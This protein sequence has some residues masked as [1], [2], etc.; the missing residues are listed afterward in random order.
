MG[1][2]A[3]HDKQQGFAAPAQRGNNMKNNYRVQ[4][5]LL[6]LTLAIF[7]A[8]C[9][10]SSSD[11]PPDGGNGNGNG[12]GNGDGETPELVADAGSD[13]TVGVGETV[14][15]DGSDSE[16]DIASYAWE[17]SDSSGVDIEIDD[18]DQETASFEATEAGDFRFL[19]RVTDTSG[20]NDADFVHVTVQADLSDAERLLYFVVPDADT[21]H[22]RKQLYAVDPAQAG[23]EHSFPVFP[24]A[25]DNGR[26][27][28]DVDASFFRATGNFRGSIGV[29][30]PWN[31]YEPDESNLPLGVLE[32]SSGSTS[33]EVSHHAVVYNTPEGQLYRVNADEGTPLSSR[34]SSENDAEVVCA[35]MVLSDHNNVEDS[36]I[37]YQVAIDDGDCNSTQWR[38]VRL[39][40]GESTAPVVLIDQVDYNDFRT[41]FSLDW[42]L[43]I[44]DGSG[45]LSDVILYDGDI[46]IPPNDGRDDGEFVRYNLANGTTHDVDGFDFEH[47]IVRYRK[48]GRAG[49]DRH[50]II[51]AQVEGPNFDGNATIYAYD[52]DE[53]VFEYIADDSLS[54]NLKTV[55][56]S[57]TSQDYAIAH[58]GYL[59][60]VDIED[61]NDNT[62]RLLRINPDASPRGEGIVLTDSWS[63][64]FGVEGVSLGHDRIA[65]MYQGSAG[66][67]DRTLRAAFLD[68]SGT[69]TLVASSEMRFPAPIVSPTAPEGYLYYDLLDP[70]PD[71][72]I[73]RRISD[74]AVVDIADARWFGQTWSTRIPESG[75]EAEYLFYREGSSFRARPADADDT[76]IVVFDEQISI[77][78]MATVGYGPEIILGVR[79]LAGSIV[80]FADP[81]DPA[82]LT[83]VAPD[84][85]NPSPIPFH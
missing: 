9:G 29:G 13:Q 40:D 21:D 52:A 53:H 56:P 44:R 75:V 30:V 54:F 7:L 32:Y 18:A 46:E 62:G 38:M 26:A 78:S 1:I 66:N 25:Q 24:L 59:Y 73:A 57:L 14:T 37:A 6:A 36:R 2:G 3:L 85:T 70:D 17:Q 39:G 16:G 19:L 50:P 82:S 28:T 22:P 34:I 45:A 8:A 42:A 72:A 23:Q 71:E 55:E 58:D 65:W 81:R 10:S 43:A 83:T 76:N 49:A 12:T 41:E 15:L 20:D 69:N 68:G 48:L 79:P 11:D 33:T 60:V 4:S 67:S 77:S 64:G 61:G 27:R 63:T 74:G 5:P 84:G 47:G 31:H 35:A 80:Y 51:Q